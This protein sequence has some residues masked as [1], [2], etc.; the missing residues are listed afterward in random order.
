MYKG[1]LGLWRN[2]VGI[3]ARQVPAGNPTA[4]D[5]VTLFDGA[6]SHLVARSIRAER[7]AEAVADDVILIG[8]L[9]FRTVVDGKDDCPAAPP[10]PAAGV[11]RQPPVRARL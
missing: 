10:R 11:C 1:T 7:D 8:P 4:V 3:V 2:L 5:E 6:E 9:E